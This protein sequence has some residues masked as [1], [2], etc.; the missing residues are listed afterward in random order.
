MKS[1]FGKCIG[2]LLALLMVMVPVLPAAASVPA[3]GPG[4]SNSSQ[5]AEMIPFED[6]DGSLM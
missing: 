3:D 6:V 2:L 5:K 4:L 1:R